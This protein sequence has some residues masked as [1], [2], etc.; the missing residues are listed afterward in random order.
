V[1]VHVDGALHE[2]LTRLSEQLPYARAEFGDDYAG[3]VYHCA[4]C[5]SLDAVCAPADE[6]VD[7]YPCPSCGHAQ[8]PITPVGEPSPSFGR[9]ER[10]AAARRARRR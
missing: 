3:R 6:L 8:T 5:S 2:L 10:R 9:A 1:T 7:D 4:P